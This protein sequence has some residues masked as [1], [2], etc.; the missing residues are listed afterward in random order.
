MG[1]MCQ[2]SRFLLEPWNPLDKHQKSI[3]KKSLS[4]RVW[5][6][7]EENRKIYGI[8][9]K[10]GP[11]YRS[12]NHVFSGHKICK[13]TYIKSLREL[14]RFFYERNNY[15]NTRKI[16]RKHD[17]KM[18]TFFFYLLLP[19]WFYLQK[20]NLFRYRYAKLEN[21]CNRDCFLKLFES[22]NIGGKKFNLKILSVEIAG[23]L[24]REFPF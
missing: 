5:V 22:K 13:S 8:K 15:R 23:D 24:P 4:F 7:R 21:T 14:L 16:A 3:I 1:V 11:R 12:K 9:Q 20:P 2:V 10:K 18:E 17:K 19:S 6:L